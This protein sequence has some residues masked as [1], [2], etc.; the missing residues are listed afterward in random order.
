MAKKK[1]R[2]RTRPPLDRRHYRAIDLLT[3]APSMNRAIIARECGVNRRTLLRWELRKDF[4]I[5]R[6]K[7]MN[8][9]MEPIR[10]RINRARRPL[11]NVDDIEWTLRINKL[12]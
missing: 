11:N 10:N 8:R 7:V 2:K 3:T 1:R 12:L 4:E 9:K 6:T 5:E